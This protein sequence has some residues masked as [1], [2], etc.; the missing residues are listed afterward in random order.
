MISPSVELAANL[1]GKAFRFGIF[2]G[3]FVTQN[4]RFALVPQW[5][6]AWFGQ[7]DAGADPAKVSAGAPD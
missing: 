3:R 7:C 1:S 6:S 2:G 5:K 4:V